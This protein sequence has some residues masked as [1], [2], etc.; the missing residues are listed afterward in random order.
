MG[1]FITKDPIGIKGGINLYVY[2]SNNPINYADPSG[3][4]TVVIGA[5]GSATAGGGAEI[6]GG[7]LV[8]PGLGGEPAD[9]GTFISVG[10]GGGLSVGGDIFIGIVSGPASNVEGKTVNI[11][12]GAGPASVTIFTDPVTGSV[13]G[14]TLGIGPSATPL[15]GTLTVSLT[16]TNTI[17]KIVDMLDKIL[18]RHV[19]EQAP[20]DG[21][22]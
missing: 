2:T 1:R 15:S 21:S 6:S 7:V 12:I 4:F 8:N 13:L 9:L 17:S 22:K 14:G 5:G 16:G 10:T 18:N 19:P 11:N 20:L 3:L